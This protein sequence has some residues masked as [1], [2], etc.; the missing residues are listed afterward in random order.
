MKREFSISIITIFLLLINAT[1]P[2]CLNP[3]QPD[4]LCSSCSP[5]QNLISGYCVTP[6]QGCITQISPSI[7]TLCNSSYILTKNICLPLQT[8]TAAPPSNNPEQQ[9]YIYTD[10]APNFRY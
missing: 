10:N 9:L 8:V 6:L 3:S 2:T 4:G 1:S 7:C 5:S